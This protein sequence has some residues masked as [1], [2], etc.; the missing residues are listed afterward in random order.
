MYFVASKEVDNIIVRELRRYFSD[1]AAYSWIF[2]KDYSILGEP[3][4]RNNENQP[5]YLIAASFPD[6]FRYYPSITIKTAI[7]KI[8]RLDVDHLIVQGDKINEYGRRTFKDFIRG[9]QITIAF[10]CIVRAIDRVEAEEITDLLAYWSVYDGWFNLK[11][12]QAFMEPFSAPGG[13]VVENLKDSTDQKK[14]YNVT[15]GTTIQVNWLKRDDPEFPTI[16]KVTVTEVT[17]NFTEV[18]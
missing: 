13:V 7:Q 4:K 9:G 11:K 14:V 2:P 12:I 5:L 10:T 3:F 6:R 8:H 15:L 16:S 1:V 17:D 18:D